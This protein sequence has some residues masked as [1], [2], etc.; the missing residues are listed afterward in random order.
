MEC[1]LTFRGFRRV[2]VCR[3]T[4]CNI[5]VLAFDIYNSLLCTVFRV[6]HYVVVLIP[7]LQDLHCFPCSLLYFFLTVSYSLYLDFLQ[8]NGGL[9]ERAS[10]P[11][12]GS[13]KVCVYST[14]LIPPTC[15]IPP[16]MLFLLYII[17]VIDKQ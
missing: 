2:G 4:S 8:L 17:V 15:E 9:S 13:G 7:F 1:S 3:G 10:L 6:S 12:R 14:F 5:V 11:P 16:G